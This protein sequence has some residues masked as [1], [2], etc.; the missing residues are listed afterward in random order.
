MRAWKNIL[1]KAFKRYLKNK[2]EQGMEPPKSTQEIFIER[3]HYYMLHE[4]THAAFLRPAP[5]SYI[6]KGRF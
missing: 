2:V 1:T 3:A 6:F 4:M 5:K